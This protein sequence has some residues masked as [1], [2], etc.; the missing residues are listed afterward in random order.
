MNRILNNT[1]DKVVVVSQW[2][3]VLDIL[4]NFLRHIKTIELNGKTPIKNRNDI[5]VNFNNPNKSERVS[6]T[7]R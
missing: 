4:K 1:N 6:K 3:S 5:V 2:T 7:I